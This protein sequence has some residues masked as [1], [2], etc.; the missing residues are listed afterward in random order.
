M[1]ED[2]I[3]DLDETHNEQSKNEGSGDSKFI[4]VREGVRHARGDGRHCNYTELN[5][6]EFPQIALVIVVRGDPGIYVIQTRPDFGH[7]T[8]VRRVEVKLYHYAFLSSFS[9]MTRAGHRFDFQKTMRL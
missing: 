4:P 7:H 3:E 6:S 9:I 1:T 8:V 2:E 5:Q